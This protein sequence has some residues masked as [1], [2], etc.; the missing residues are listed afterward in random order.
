MNR[1]FCG[2]STSIETVPRELVDAFPAFSM[3][4]AAVFWGAKLPDSPFFFL[5]MKGQSRL[6]SFSGRFFMPLPTSLQG[7][8]AS[9]A[10]QNKALQNRLTIRP[11]P[12]TCRFSG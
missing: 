11:S 3:A 5:D 6:A 9:F 2:E 7:I 8:A 12:T 10:D 4:S 1:C